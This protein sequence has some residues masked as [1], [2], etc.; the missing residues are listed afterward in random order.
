MIKTQ[1]VSSIE[2][3]QNNWMDPYFQWFSAGMP[4]FTTDNL[5]PWKQIFIK[6]ETKED[7]QAFGEL[8][9]QSLTDK[10]TVV[11]FPEKKREQNNMNRIV[12][13]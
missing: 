2:E 1:I 13:D 4:A 7:R 8:I 11:W 5:E 3:L 6:F 12:E 10:T 9:K